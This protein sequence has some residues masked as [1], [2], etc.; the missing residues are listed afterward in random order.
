MSTRTAMEATFNR[1]RE[2]HARHGIGR[3]MNAGQS[4]RY[5]GAMIA[6]QDAHAAL[7]EAETRLD[8]TLA[9]ISHEQDIGA[10][11]MGRSHD[12]VDGTAWRDWAVFPASVSDE[13]ALERAGF[14]HYY[15][16]PGRAFDGDGYVARRTATRV[17]V[18][19]SGGLDI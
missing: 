15:R 17:L 10:I 4:A 5:V 13:D 3:P 1:A 6:L 18:T 11:A 7:Q 2:M 19:A 16:G 8:H 12:K 14:T 9:R